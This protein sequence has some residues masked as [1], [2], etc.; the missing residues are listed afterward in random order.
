MN[1]QDSY[2]AYNEL[3]IYPFHMP[4]HKRNT[5]LCQLDNPYSI[6]YTEIDGLDDLHEASA[7]PNRESL[8]ANAMRRASRLFGS[9]YSFYLVGGS[10]SGLICSILACTRRG[11][12]VLIPRNCHKS[13]YNALA[14]AGLRPIYIY[15]STDEAFGVYANLRPEDV[16]RAFET[17]PNIKLAVLVSPTFYGIVSD[18]QAIADVVHEYGAPLLVDEAHGPHM[19]FHPFFPESAVKT[20]ADIVVQSLHKTL[21]VLT[22]TSILHIASD[23]VDPEAVSRNLA[24]IESSSPSYVLMA[25]ADQCV[26]LLE[27]RGDELFKVYV[28]RLKKFS[29]DMRALKHLKILCHGNDEDMPHPNIYH[30]DHGKILI[31]TRGTSM[32]GAKLYRVLLEKYKLQMEMCLKDMVLAMTSPADTEEG[33]RRLTEALLEIDA[34]LEEG[35]P[36][37]EFL[38][39]Q[40]TIEVPDLTPAEAYALEGEFVKPSDAVGRIARE[41]VYAYPPGIPYFVPGER[42]DSATMETI[43]QME[44]SDIRLISTRHL[45][46]ERIE[47]CIER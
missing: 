47:V 12:R 40:H 31:S 32:S 20:G 15:P 17:Y 21:P 38:L 19:T 28:D 6:D 11:D 34:S 36:G 30:Y 16:R 24:I 37:Q 27:E 26:D 45:Y 2:R 42:I 44:T 9:R 29:D 39:K 7:H 8:L 5:E 35:A 41:F 46:P 1:L 25:S 22:Q 10:T 13:V 18:V 3:N 33:F 43:R 23:R 14:L 4:G